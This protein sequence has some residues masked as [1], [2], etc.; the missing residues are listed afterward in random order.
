MIPI[1]LTTDNSGLSVTRAA[2]ISNLATQNAQDSERELAM[3]KAFSTSLVLEGNNNTEVEVETGNVLSNDVIKRHID[4][5]TSNYALVAYIRNAIKMKEDYIR[6][7]VER[8]SPE[9]DL[10]IK[11][12]PLTPPPI[13]SPLPPSLDSIETYLQGHDY[14]ADINAL[15]DY[16][17]VEAKAAHIGKFIHK[18]GHLTNIRIQLADT[19]RLEVRRFGMTEKLIK[20]KAL[21]NSEQLLGLHNALAVLHRQAE[22]KVNYYK[23]DADNSTLSRYNLAVEQWK[24]KMNQVSETNR[25]QQQEYHLAY[26]AWR[27]EKELLIMQ[28]EA[29]TKRLVN[30]AQ[31]LK[32]I[33][34]DAL[35]GIVEQYLALTGEL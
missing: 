6:R 29:E 27:T 10:H 28:H 30:E 24:L 12:M 9:I 26:E 14:V 5:I 18:D 19:N 21:Y 32:I 33:V 23:A 16:L 8:P 7:I 35:S 1:V 3:I 13:E 11:R 4:I 34:P 17:M 20:R 15:T 2:F 31:K 22:A 25:K